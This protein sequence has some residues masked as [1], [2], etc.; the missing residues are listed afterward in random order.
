MG[1]V[2]LCTCANNDE[3]NSDCTIGQLVNSSYTRSNTHMFER[4]HHNSHHN[5]TSNYYNIV[6]L[7]ISNTIIIIIALYYHNLF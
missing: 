1:I 6:Q 5:L 2:I 4:S 7:L 3:V